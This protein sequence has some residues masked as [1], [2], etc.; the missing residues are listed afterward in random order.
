MILNSTINIFEPFEASTL[1][2][3]LTFPKF[4]VSGQGTLRTPPPFDASQTIPPVNAN[5][6]KQ[7]VDRLLWGIDGGFRCDSPQKPYRCVVSGELDP[8]NAERPETHLPG[9]QTSFTAQNAPES[10]NQKE[11]KEKAEKR[12]RLREQD[13]SYVEPTYEEPVPNISHRRLPRRM[14]EKSPLIKDSLITQVDKFK[15]RKRKH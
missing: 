5:N 8:I 4:G 14:R 15:R 9:S 7:L 1:V 3:E 6:R 12:I 2:F 13:P 11:A 10:S